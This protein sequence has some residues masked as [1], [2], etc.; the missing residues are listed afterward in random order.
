M[1]CLLAVV[2]LASSCSSSFT[3]GVTE[4]F[5]DLSGIYR[6]ASAVGSMGELQL[7]LERIEDTTWFDAL[8][9]SDLGSEIN[10]SIGFLTL[11]DRH[12][13]INFDR[14]LLSD[15]YFEGTVVMD[16]S[17]VDS[18]EGQFVFPDMEETLAVTFGR[19]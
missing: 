6:T 16:G 9:E 4:P 8:V 19:T 13:V 12:V 2:A 1:A 10:T 18:L 17:E 5:I 7:R 11:G 3:V 14:G 15:Y